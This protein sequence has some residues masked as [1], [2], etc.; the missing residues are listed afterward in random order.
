MKKYCITT[1]PRSRTQIH[2]FALQL[3]N[4]L[5][6][7]IDDYVQP[8]KL[9]DL[10]AYYCDKEGFDYQVLP[11]ENKCFVQNRDEAFTDLKTGKIYIR[12]S[13]FKKACCRKYDRAAF[14]LVHEIG[15]FLLHFHCPAYLYRTADDGGVKAYVK[16]EW[17][18]DT[19]ADDI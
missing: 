12:E 11:D 10:L 3:R 9:F 13:V 18:A 7:S 19:F 5:N 1:A 14:T 2:D 17:Q 4:N 15:P 8:A 16:V 6:L